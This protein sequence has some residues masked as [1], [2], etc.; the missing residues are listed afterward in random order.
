M[1]HDGLDT[2]RNSGVCACGVCACGVCACGV[3]RGRDLGL[4]GL[5]NCRECVWMGCGRFELKEYGLAGLSGR[6]CS[7]EKL[8]QR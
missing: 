5:R 2:L 1:D 3:C 6:K 8:R 7:R 4:A